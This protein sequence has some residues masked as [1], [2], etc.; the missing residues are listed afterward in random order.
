M[1]GGRGYGKGYGRGNGPGGYRIGGGRWWD[2][3]AGGNYGYGRGL[4]LGLGRYNGRGNPLPYCRWNPNLPRGWWRYQGTNFNQT[5]NVSIPNAGNYA[6]YVPYRADS[7]AIDYQI[8]LIKNQIDFLEKEIDR[9]K[10]L[11]KRF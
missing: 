8:N 7:D 1:R 6:P 3:G 9:L 10:S 11:K 2:T 4:G 5:E